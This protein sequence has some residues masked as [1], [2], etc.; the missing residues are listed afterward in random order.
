[1][2]VWENPGHRYTNGEPIKLLV[3]ISGADTV[4]LKS[5][6]MLSLKGPVRLTGFVPVCFVGAVCRAPQHCI[7][8]TWLGEQC[9]GRGKWAQARLT[10]DALA[11]P[12]IRWD[13]NLKTTLAGLG[14]TGNVF[15]LHFAELECESWRLSVP[16]GSQ[17]G[18]K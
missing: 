16:G 10:T 13:G 5:A 2:H 14:D 7:Q 18:L 8:P 12:S 1:M 17:F 15:S 4:K 6:R 9:G 3:G 11:S